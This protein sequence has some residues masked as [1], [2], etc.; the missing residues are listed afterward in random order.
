[1]ATKRIYRPRGMYKVGT[2]V[3]EERAPLFKQPSRVYVSPDITEGLFLAVKA[4]KHV[5]VYRR[6]RH[7]SPAPGHPLV[8][9][10][11]KGCAMK[12]KGIANRDERVKQIRE[13]IISEFERRN[14]P[15]TSGA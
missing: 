11:F 14:I 15:K 7:P 10:I 9:A 6:T 5:T 3:G 1:M 13:C 4:K 2:T 8:K 12:T